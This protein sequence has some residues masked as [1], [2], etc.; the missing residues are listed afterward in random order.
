MKI[1]VIGAG[2]SGLGAAH[3]LSGAHEV[4]VFEKA[5]RPGGHTNTVHLPDGIAV[6]T[7]FIVHNRENYPNFVRLMEE[8]GVPAAPSDM[9]F[10]YAGPEL[11][12]CSLGLNG[13]LTERRHLFSRR[14]WRFWSEVRRFNAWGASQALDALASERTL[15]SALDEAGFSRDFRQA[16]LY[17]MAGAVWSTPVGEMD[18]FPKRNG[19]AQT[20]RERGNPPVFPKSKDV[21]IGK[22]LGFGQQILHR[23]LGMGCALHAIRN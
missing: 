12:W 7:G 18:A 3:A 10:A 8:L 5:R 9:S 19:K 15:R 17:P 11:S 4:H 23:D 2:I 13:L 1:A 22:N 20:Y 14:F 6:D 16:Y 21:A